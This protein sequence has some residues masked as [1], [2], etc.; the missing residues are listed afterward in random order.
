MEFY[1]RNWLI[2][3][4]LTLFVIT[5][6][7]ISY[8]LGI[9]VGKAEK[10]K[11]ETIIDIAK[12]SNFKEKNNTSIQKDINI[13]EIKKAILTKSTNISNYILIKYKQSSD[14][15][16]KYYQKDVNESGMISSTKNAIIDTYVGGVAGIKNYYKKFMDDEKSLK[17][18]N[19]SK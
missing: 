7:Y 10:L 16:K 4:A 12:N 17:D 8:N 14:K 5:T 6:V 9:N 15:I 2:G 11:N 18:L 19:N 13:S 3:L 1:M